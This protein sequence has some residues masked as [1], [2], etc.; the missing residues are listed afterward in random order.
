[1]ND[2][3]EKYI[4]FKKKVK[5]LWKKF[6]ERGRK[7]LTI[8][9][10]PHNE[11]KIFNFQISH[12]TISFFTIL[13]VIVVVFSIVSLNDHETSQ[14]K[15]TRLSNLSRTR[16]GQIR[17]FKNRTT[18]AYE[19]FNEFKD[20]ITQL[21]ANIGVKKSDNVFPFY[22]R[23]GIDSS[24]T[25]ELQERYGDAFAVP[26]EIQEL[27]ILN[28]NV[29]QSTEQLK[30]VNSFIDNMKQVM[31]Y[32]PSLWPVAGGGFITSPFGNRVNPFTGI[33]G[34][35][36]GVDIAWWPGS[37]IR[38]SAAG[39]IQSASYQGGYGLTVLIRHKYGFSTRYAHLQR[40]NVGAGQ[41]VEKGQI[42]GTMGNTGFATGYHLHYEVILGNTVVDPEPYLTS[43]F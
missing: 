14:T 3:H 12:F 23:G 19:S 22:G 8:M 29:I 43:K 17:A 13:L 1:M 7:E 31:Q 35:H 21:A 34:L 33:Y 27:E 16:E 39:V 37:P 25:S 2:L 26:R 4:R 30:R 41:S 6:M 32:T 10:V 20:Q 36:T 42:I 24:I 18:Y 9:L 5:T 40:I 28:R 15:I 38:T 11:K